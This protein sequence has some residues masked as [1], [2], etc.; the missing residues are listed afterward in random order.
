MDWVDTTRNVARSDQTRYD[1]YK[2]PECLHL[3]CE[4]MRVFACIRCA[5]LLAECIC[6]YTTL[7]EYALPVSNLFVDHENSH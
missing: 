4:F 1:V 7:I 5:E 3:Q 2:G 6:R